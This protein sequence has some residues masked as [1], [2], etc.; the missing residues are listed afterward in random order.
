VRAKLVVSHKSFQTMEKSSSTAD[1]ANPGTGSAS[2]AS[3]APAKSVKKP[4]L[5]KLEATNNSLWLVKVPSFVASKLATAKSGNVVGS[6][7]ITKDPTKK[8]GK[9]ININILSEASDTATTPF[10][11]EEPPEFDKTKATTSADDK[12]SIMSFTYDKSSD[13]YSVHGSVTKSLFLK[14]QDSEIYRKYLRERGKSALPSKAT[15]EADIQSVLQAKSSSHIIDFIPPAHAELKKKRQES[16]LKGVDGATPLDSD[17][18]KAKMFQCFAH[19]PRQSLKD[20]IAFCKDVAGFTRERDLKF[21]LEQY[22]N[23]HQKGMYKGQ[24][25]LK[26]EYQGATSPPEGS[27]TMTSGEALSSALK[28]VAANISGVKRKL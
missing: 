9:A 3:K 25:E 23:Y 5:H 21:I 10:T 11:L 4:M 8:G 27:V 26:V 24:W 16:S 17:A 1:G 19:N 28:D 12:P 22:A 18:L 14:P 13:E 20:L 2:S 15:K 6:L 7:S